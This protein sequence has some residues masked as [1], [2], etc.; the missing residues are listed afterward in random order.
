M[1]SL[2]I[3]WGALSGIGTV[4]KEVKSLKV[5]LWPND[6]PCHVIAQ[7]LSSCFYIMHI[8]SVAKKRHKPGGQTG[9]LKLVTGQ[10][11]SN[12]GWPSLY[13][14]YFNL[15]TWWSSWASF[16]RF[17]WSTLMVSVMKVF[18]TSPEFRILAKKMTF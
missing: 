13:N 12:F 5:A 17:W 11:I 1:V 7:E 3:A 8:G 15:K 6:V 14:L 2:S 18:R 4:S 16:F 10:P 9:P